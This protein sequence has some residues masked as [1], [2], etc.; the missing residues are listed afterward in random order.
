MEFNS[1]LELV[2]KRLGKWMFITLLLSLWAA[3]VAWGLHTAYDNLG[4]PIYRFVSTHN[5]ANLIHYPSAVWTDILLAF[6]MVVFVLIVS[7]CSAVLVIWFFLS[8]LR[9]IFKSFSDAWKATPKISPETAAVMESK[10]QET[11]LPII[12]P[13]EKI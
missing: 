11:S 9:Q 3:G 6:G 10:A 1:I 8:L 7:V 5:V 4:A 2:D 12:P 13:L